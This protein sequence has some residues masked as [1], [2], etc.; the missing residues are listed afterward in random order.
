MRIKDTVKIYPRIAQMKH[1]KHAEKPKGP[2][3]A[4]VLGT[5]Q[6]GVTEKSPPSTA[7]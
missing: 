5:S 1:R 7:S 4:H 2:T 3:L 6:S